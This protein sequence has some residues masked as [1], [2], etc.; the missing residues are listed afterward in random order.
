MVSAVTPSLI[1][2]TNLYKDG[3]T[4]RKKS[5]PILMMFSISNCAYCEKV[6]NDVLKP[7]LRSGDYENKIIIRHLNT[8]KKNKII[9]FANKKNSAQELALFY[10]INFFPTIILVNSKGQPLFGH[11]VGIANEDYYWYDLDIA[12]MS[13]MN[14]FKTEQ[15]YTQ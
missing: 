9:D 1:N 2:A 5:L 4:A 3:E 12:I 13:A 6:K 11:I 8:S 7:M 15:I 10:G 14:A